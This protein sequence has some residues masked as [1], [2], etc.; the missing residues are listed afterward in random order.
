ML[1]IDEAL[2]S[3][4]NGRLP[5]LVRQ[6]THVER[7]NHTRASPPRASRCAML[8]IHTALTRLARL[9]RGVDVRAPT[10]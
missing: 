7:H 9:F 8:S 4:T 2:A 6:G 1:V 3:E 10:A 5:G